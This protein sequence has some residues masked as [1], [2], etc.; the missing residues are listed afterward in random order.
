MPDP[1]DRAKLAQR[2]KC[3]H[4]GLS[5]AAERFS[6]AS[7]DAARVGLA[8]L[9]VAGGRRGVPAPTYRKYSVLDSRA[10]QMFLQ[11]RG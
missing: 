1:G 2:K 11:R 3:R 7:M 6:T 5:A 9:R 10:Y 4:A 8:V